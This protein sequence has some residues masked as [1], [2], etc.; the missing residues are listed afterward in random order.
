MTDMSG[1]VHW[2]NICVMY[3]KAMQ[4]LVCMMKCADGQ[5]F[6]RVIN[7]LLCKVY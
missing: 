5:L 1:H 4:T 2:Q 6:C 3:G 7:D